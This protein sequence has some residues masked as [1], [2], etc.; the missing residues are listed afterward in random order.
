MVVIMKR[1]SDWYHRS[2]G[3]SAAVND[4]RV[5][6][7]IRHLIKCTSVKRH[8]CTNSEKWVLVR[9]G[10][11]DVLSRPVFKVYTED[12]QCHGV[13]YP[14]VLG[15]EADTSVLEQYLDGIDLTVNAEID[16]HI[17]S[18]ALRRETKGEDSVIESTDSVARPA[19]QK[20][21]KG[22]SSKSQKSRKIRTKQNGQ[23]AVES[24]G[25][26]C[27]SQTAPPQHNKQTTVISLIGDSQRMLSLVGQVTAVIQGTPVQM[28][29]VNSMHA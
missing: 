14:L 29:V 2:G 20:S 25:H 16:A 1:Y 12:K 4:E 10:D 24:D 6:H 13:I 8:Y 5:M 23:I 28:T 18:A 3:T 26:A 22:R 27:S 7:A 11:S 15:E 17:E 9:E 19:R 21:K